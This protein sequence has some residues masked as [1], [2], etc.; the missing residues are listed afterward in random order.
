MPRGQ[1][2]TFELNNEYRMS[3]LRR[4]KAYGVRVWRNITIEPVVAFYLTAIGLNEVIRPNLLLDKS[5]LF[6][7]NFTQEICN[8]INEDA[9]KVNEQNKHILFTSRRAQRNTYCKNC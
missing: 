6:V 5:C 2:I 7:H 1:S 3:F 4:I 8:D 9:Y